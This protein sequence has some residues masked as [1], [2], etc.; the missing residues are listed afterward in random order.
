M[1]VTQQYSKGGTSIEA[2]R[3]GLAVSGLPNLNSPGLQASGVTKRFSGVAA[4][5]QVSI[6]IPP[7]QI[8]GLAGHNG[9]GKSTL[10]KLLS[11]VYR[12]DEGSVLLDGPPVELHSPRQALALGIVTV[13]QELS[14]LGNLTATQN[15]FLAK[16]RTQLGFLQ[17]SKMRAE[18]QQMVERFGLDIDVDRPV[19]A[20]PVATR[21]LLELAIATHRN[22]RFLLLDLSLIHI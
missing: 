2:P 13:H 9:A 11:G 3:S 17:R 5:T 18:A 19:G 4:L 21:Q 10:L 15:T 8:V 1:A 6:A 12:P 14:L 7:A 16:E 20:Y 22:A